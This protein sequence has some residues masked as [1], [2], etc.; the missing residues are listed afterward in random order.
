MANKLKGETPLVL[1][2]GRQ[3]TLMLDMEAMLSV[4]TE[5]GKPLPRVMAMAQEGFMTAIAAIA[6]AAF[7]RKHPQITRTD[8]LDIMV[9]DRDALVAALTSAANAAF[10]DSTGEAGNAESRQA[11]KT[12]GGNGAKQG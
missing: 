11:G 10:P 6:Q 2:D 3:F 12:S 8:V 4:E 1:K 7:S 9:S 5:M